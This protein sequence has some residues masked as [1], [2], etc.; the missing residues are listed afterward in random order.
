MSYLENCV[1]E[2]VLTLTI[3]LQALSYAENCVLESV[4]TLTMMITV[5]PYIQSCILENV[6]TSTIMFTVSVLYRKLCLA[7]NTHFNHDV[8]SQCL[9]TKHNKKGK[10][11]SQCHYWELECDFWDVP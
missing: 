8:Y 4:L 6:L 7:E 5:M 2:N 3:Y 11:A 1:L 9:V 10:F